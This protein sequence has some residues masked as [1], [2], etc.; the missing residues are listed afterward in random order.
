MYRQKH[1]HRSNQRRT[2]KTS[3]V[4]FVLHKVHAFLKHCFSN[5]NIP[6]CTSAQCRYPYRII[7]KLPT[8]WVPVSQLYQTYR[9]VRFQH[10]ND[11]GLP[12]V[13]G[14]VVREIPV[15]RQRRGTSI[16]MIPLTQMS[17]TYL[18]QIQNFAIFRVPESKQYS[19]H[20]RTEGRYRFPTEQTPVP[21][22]L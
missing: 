3:I 4:P 22:L 16:K 20:K 5:T 17:G 6:L 9:C 7:S 10:R 19:T 12:Q 13:R 14:T 2:I 15:V 1:G 18:E 8:C 21:L 11:T